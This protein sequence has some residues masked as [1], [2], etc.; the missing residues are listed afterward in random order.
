VK[1][2][3]IMTHLIFIHGMI[4]ITNLKPA[5]ANPPKPTATVRDATI[6]RGVEA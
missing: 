4:L 2:N 6:A 1:R 5:K 3:L